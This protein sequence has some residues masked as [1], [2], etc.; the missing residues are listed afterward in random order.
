ML[1]LLVNKKNI[2][3]NCSYIPLLFPFWGPI[4]KDTT[5]YLTGVFEMLSFDKKYYRLTENLTEVDCILLPHNYWTL[6]KYDPGYLKN[7]IHKAQMLK[8]PVLIDATGDCA[9]EVPIKNS[10]VLRNSIYK[11]SLKNKE[12]VVPAYAEDFG[13]FIPRKLP[14]VPTI[15]FAGWAKENFFKSLYI[16]ERTPGLV[17]RNLAIKYLNKTAGIKTN[18]ILR[19]SYSGHIKTISGSV[20]QYRTEFVDN[21]IDSDYTLCVK[22]SGNFSVRFYETLSLGRIPL[23]IDT[24]CVFP[25]EEKI[26]YR[27]FCLFVSYRNLDKI[28]KLLLDFHRSL[29]SNDFFNKQNEAREVFDKYLRIDSFT[30]YLVDEIKL[31]I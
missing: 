31:R 18:F 20:K 14:L 8:K 2:S 16:T 9:D 26:N 3:H 27:E 15:G 22:G 21:I 5:P 10:I 19:K 6:K 12:I 30:K 4:L 29:S 1:T 25:L 28:G 24:D 7:F 13:K 17:I 11:K 23:V